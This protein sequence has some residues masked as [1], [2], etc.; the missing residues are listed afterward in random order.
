MALTLTDRL[1][2]GTAKSGAETVEIAAGEW[3]R[4]QYGAAGDPTT[5]IQVQVPS[6]KKWTAN[7]FVD[8]LEQA[9]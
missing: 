6:G 7:I 8:I 2:P 4:V 9:A 3:L 5:M 1:L